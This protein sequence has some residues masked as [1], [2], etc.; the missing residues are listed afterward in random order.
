MVPASTPDLDEPATRWT[1]IAGLYGFLVATAIMVLLVPMS[2]TIASVLGLR[3][4]F[5]LATLALPTTIISAAIWWPVVEHRTD[6]RYRTAAAYGLLTALTTTT[7]WTLYFVIIWSPQMAQAGA[8]LIGFV[9][10]ITTPAGILIGLPLMA[11][12]R[13]YVERPTPEQ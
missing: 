8:I 13:R 11:A 3:G 2:T 5:A 10:A 4:T 1:A 7:A 12:R 6:Y 9:Y